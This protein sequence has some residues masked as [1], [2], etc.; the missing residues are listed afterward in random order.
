[1]DSY[2]A[3][4]LG[5]VQGLTEFLPIS[6]SAHL[7]VIPEL[8]GWGVSPLAFDVVLHV[9]TA[10]ALLA[11]FWRDLLAIATAFFGNAK[12]FGTAFSKYSYE[13][14]FGAY[15]VIGALPAAFFGYFLEEHISGEVRSTFFVSIF[16]LLGSILM[17][18]AESAYTGTKNQLTAKQSLGIG[19]FQA[20]A[21]LPGISRSGSTISGGMLLGLNRVEAARFSFLVV[22]PVV[23]GAGLF[24]VLESGGELLVLGAGPVV[25]GFIIST[26][27]GLVAI[28]FLLSFLR[29][30]TLYIFII[31]R[32]FLAAT[33]LYL[34]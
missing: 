8:F 11:V 24:K 19:F 17:L 12:S 1:M 32:L 21:L 9:G 28:K 3:I 2:Q 22:I 5:I 30:H 23:L 31:Y 27:V 7:I 20:L 6:S 29:T 25:L 14:K 13:G 15:L 4:V 18:L 26:V 33:L 34:S 16:L 10:V